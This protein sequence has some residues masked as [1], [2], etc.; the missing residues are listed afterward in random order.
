MSRLVEVSGHISN[1]E[2]SIRFHLELVHC[3]KHG[4]NRARHMK[5]HKKCN[6]ILKWCISFWEHTRQLQV[7]QIH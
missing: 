2:A 4:L 7:A 1:F 3:C 5:Q 6:I